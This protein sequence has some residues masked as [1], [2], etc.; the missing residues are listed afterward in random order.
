MTNV[1]MLKMMLKHEVITVMDAIGVEAMLHVPCA[2]R[3]YTGTGRF[4]LYLRGGYDFAQMETGP[5][6]FL[7][8]QPREPFP[9]AAMRKHRSTLISITDM[10]C[11]FVLEKVPPYQKQKMVEES[12]PFIRPGRELYLPFLGVVLAAGRKSAPDRVEQISFMTQKLLLTVLYRHIRRATGTKLAE[13]LGVSCMSITRC[14]DEL[15]VLVPTL[16]RQ[17]GRSRLL[18]WDGT[19]RDYWE[20]IR[21][22]LRSPVVKS[23]YLE[24]PLDVNLPLGGMSAVCSYSMLNENSY[25]TYGVIKS[26]AAKLR[27]SYLPQVPVGEAPAMA[28][29]VMGYDLTLPG[30]E[31]T[32]DPLTAILSLR[33][34]ERSDPRVEGAI[35][36]I[37]ERYIDERP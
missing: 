13:E 20:T 15:E 2:T 34:D 22:I 10:E 26:T 21:P 1:R 31:K 11:A 16:I 7:L 14:Q 18:A 6:S 17:E 4:P 3:S 5:V 25:P 24:S 33:E 27:L 9:L 35:Q 37:E 36:E 29:L 32:C 28:V 30:C 23:Y 19:W 12:I 8:A